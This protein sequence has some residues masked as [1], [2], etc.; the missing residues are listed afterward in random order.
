MFEGIHATVF[1]NMQHD[2][3][4]SHMSTILCLQIIYFIDMHNNLTIYKV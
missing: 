4:I 1:I 2:N 3:C